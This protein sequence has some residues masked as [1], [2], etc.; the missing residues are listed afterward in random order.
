MVT[1]IYLSSARR[2]MMVERAGQGEEEREQDEESMPC[3]HRGRGKEEEGSK[4]RVVSP[5]PLGRCRAKG[6]EK[7]K[8]DNLIIY[9]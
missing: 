2:W 3:V 9:S 8:R 1:L 5:P 4:Q 6:E 7:K